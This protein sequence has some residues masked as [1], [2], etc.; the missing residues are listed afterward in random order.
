MK[1]V[2]TPL[3]GV[4][5]IHCHL[6]SDDRGDFLKLFHAEAYQS[7]SPQFQIR[8]IYH[9]KSKRGVIRGL[10]YQLPPFAMDKIIFCVRGAIYDACVDVRPSSP[11]FGKHFLIELNEAN[12]KGVFVPKGF[13]HGLQAL[14]D[15]TI[16]INV[17]SEIY[18][19]SHE[20][21]VAWHSCGI[22]WSGDTP[23][24]SEKDQAQPRLEE[25]FAATQ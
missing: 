22:S 7:I 18:V 1:F 17:A 23:I 4:F 5:E 14:S 8:E 19:P 11:T 13:A 16:I 15:N 21:G 12:G 25:L 6:L 2:S 10:H 24:V 3:E 20:R 9:S